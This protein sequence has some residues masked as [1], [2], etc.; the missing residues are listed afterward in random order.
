MAYDQ[1]SMCSSAK[2]CLKLD[3]AGCSAEDKKPNSK[4]KY[5]DDFCAP[6]IELKNV[7]SH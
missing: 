6:Y 1:K 3:I 2:Q 5:N 7:A 4:I